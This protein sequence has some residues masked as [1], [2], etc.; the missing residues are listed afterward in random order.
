MSE[1]ADLAL[2]MRLQEEENQRERQQA[3][4][5]RQAAAAQQQ[6]QSPSGSQG[7]LQA[8]SAE[9]RRYWPSLLA[10]QLCA[11]RLGRA[12][13]SMLLPCISPNFPHCLTCEAAAILCCKL[14]ACAEAGRRGVA[15]PG[16]ESR[17]RTWQEKSGR[18]QTSRD[19]GRAPGPGRPKSA[20]RRRL[21]Y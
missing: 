5:R 12:S 13:S 4:A 16:G 18:Q 10:E 7:P 8:G 2:A 19:A 1:D 17:Q 21:V 3:L 9:E 6:Q 15:Q 20:R 11:S 14:S